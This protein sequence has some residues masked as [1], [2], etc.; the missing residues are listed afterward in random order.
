VTSIRL[1][2][3]YV[4]CERFGDG[5]KLLGNVLDT[6]A[7]VFGQ[8]S[9]LAAVG[10]GALAEIYRQTG[11]TTDA[12]PLLEKLVQSSVS[13]EDVHSYMIGTVR[14]GLGRLYC[15]A[16]R[17]D[18]AIRAWKG[19]VLDYDEG[20]L[21][22]GTTFLQCSV[23]LALLLGRRGR[24]DGA[25]K[26]LQRKMDDILSVFGYPDTEEARWTR[27]ALRLLKEFETDFETDFEESN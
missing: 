4:R 19:C 6:C 17:W 1:A 23:M 24:P 15:E 8:E 9:L 25:V 10:I 14:F 18:D 12:I 20:I 21:S 27:I 16:E 13:R 2:D 3:L 26:L 11:R 5:E 7:S 22:Q